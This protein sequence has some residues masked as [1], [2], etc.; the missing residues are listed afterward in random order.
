VPGPAYNLA[1]ET[2]KLLIHLGTGLAMIAF[3]AHQIARP[4]HWLDY[5]PRWFRQL[6]PLQDNVFMRVHGTGNLLLGLWLFS[7]LYAPVAAWLSLIWWISIL[8]FALFRDWR[9]GMR[10]IAIICGLIAYIVLL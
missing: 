5:L 3:G 7:G 9:D 2:A 6:S 8:P 1:M 10:D 4:Q